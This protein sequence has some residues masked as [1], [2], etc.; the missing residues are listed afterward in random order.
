MRVAVVHHPVDFNSSH[1]GNYNKRVKRDSVSHRCAILGLIPLESLNE[2][3]EW[4][5]SEKRIRFSS[6]RDTAGRIHKAKVSD[7]RCCCCSWWCLLGILL[8]PEILLKRLLIKNNKLFLFRFEFVAYLKFP[9]F[10]VASLALPVSETWE[11]IIETRTSFKI[12]NFPDLLRLKMIILY[13]E[14]VQTLLGWN[15]PTC[16]SCFHQQFDNF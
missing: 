11:L 14:V 7:I 8:C 3:T 16:Y 4:A 2:E 5:K 10:C 12:Y 15:V 9:D 13:L 6:E 1:V